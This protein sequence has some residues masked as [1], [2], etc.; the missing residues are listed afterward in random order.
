VC[1]TCVKHSVSKRVYE[2][3][4]LRVYQTVDASDDETSP[5][6]HGC[7]THTIHTLSHTHHSHTLSHT[8]S[9]HSLTHR[10]QRRRNKSHSQT[11]PAQGTISQK[12]HVPVQSFSDVA[13]ATCSSALT[14]TFEN[15]YQGTK[16]AERDRG[17]GLQG[18]E[19]AEGLYSKG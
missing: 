1:Q 4:S 7:L 9:T 6:V 13:V 14:L 18:P 10:C 5:T 15:V 2:T 8:P 19:R 3:E 12:S 16:R 17:R 11:I